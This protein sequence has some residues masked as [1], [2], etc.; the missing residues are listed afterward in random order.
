M[1]LDSLR[2]YL[3]INSLQYFIGIDDIEVDDVVLSG[4]VKRAISTYANWRPLFKQSDF[5]V[6]EYTTIM[7]YDTEGR[8]ILSVVDLYFFDPILAGPSGRI[9]W[10]WDYNKDNGL[11]R[12]E[13]TGSYIAELLVE[14]TLEDYDSTNTELIEMILGLYMMY[15][16]SSRKS[17]SFGD[18]PFE[19]D[20]SE[21]YSEGKE[22]W[23]NTLE[24]LKTEQDNWYLSIL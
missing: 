23:E 24:S 18:Q 14:G 2:E 16:G 17:F 22:L 9:Q 6:S 8:R 4:L 15:V 5:S 10:S 19:N 13:I 3:L 20:G 11:F 7:K 12:T 21:L 1:T